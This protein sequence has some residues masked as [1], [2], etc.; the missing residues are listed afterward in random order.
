MF[1]SIRKY[2]VK[3]GSSGHLAKRVQDDFVPL[4]RQIEGFRSYFSMAA[5]TC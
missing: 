2:K 5:P 4:M 3:R 1:A